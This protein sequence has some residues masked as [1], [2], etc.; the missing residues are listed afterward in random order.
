MVNSMDINAVI[1]ALRQLARR[2]VIAEP[3]DLQ[4]FA[5][6]VIALAAQRATEHRKKV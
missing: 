3:A 6:E 1:G 2:G 4:G 5:E